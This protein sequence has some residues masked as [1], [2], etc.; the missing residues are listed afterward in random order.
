M[1]FEIAFLVDFARSIEVSKSTSAF[2]NMKSDTVPL[3][4]LTKSMIFA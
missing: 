1:S 3:E 2:F 4:C